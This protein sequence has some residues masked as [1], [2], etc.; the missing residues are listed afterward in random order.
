MSE[1]KKEKRRGSAL[2][3][4]DRGH[5]I[6]AFGIRRSSSSAGIFGSRRNSIPVQVQPVTN[7][8]PETPIVADVIVA[9]VLPPVSS[10]VGRSFSMKSANALHNQRQRQ[11]RAEKWQLLARK[12]MGNESLGNVDEED[13]CE[14]SYGTVT[15]QALTPQAWP[16][17]NI[18]VQNL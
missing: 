12:V 18:S 10:T 8:A 15:K 11:I 7:G 3:I 17:F 5:S 6:N 4:F 13:P 2:A 9:T 16:T 1:E 14:G